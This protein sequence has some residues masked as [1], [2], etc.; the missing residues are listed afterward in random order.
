MEHFAPLEKGASD[1]RMGSPISTL[2]GGPDFHGY[3]WTDSNDPA[4]PDYK[5]NDISASGELLVE[6]SKMDDGNQEIQLP[7][8]VSFYGKEFE[9]AYINSNGYLTLGFPSNQHGHFP[10]PST[11]MPGNLIAPMA[12]D[13]NPAT[14][15]KIYVKKTGDRFTV[16][17]DKVKDFAGLGE[18]TF[19]AVLQSNG[20]IF[21]HYL[22][23]PDGVKSASTGIQN[24]TRDAGLLVGYNN[25]QI[26]SKMSVRVSTAPKWLHISKASGAIDA[27]Q[28]ESLEIRLKAGMILTGNY[29]SIL[30]LTSNDPKNLKSEIPVALDIKA[31]KFLATNPTQLNFGNV[32]VGLSKTLEFT[33]SNK[34]NAPVSLSNLKLQDAAFTSNLSA[35]SLKPG[36]NKTVNITF[37]PTKGG[38][39]LSVSSLTSDADDAPHN[40]KLT[41]TGI[42]SPK[43]QVTPETVSISVEAGNKGSIKAVID[44]VK[45]MAPG[46][47][48]W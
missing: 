27:G 7:F 46:P 29:E 39:Y 10:L 3:S 44:N 2:G 30:N 13:L 36:A 34:G 47:L 16:Q 35:T 11:M 6:L 41:G 22:S 17:Y 18:Y 42:A 32:E 8:A 45:G 37:K 26:E 48:R 12:M 1:N 31:S 21:F 5:W 19:Q 43:L 20:V 33:I 38:E 9:K 25:N 28:S 24:E 14:G 23:I 15:G 40:I 4:G